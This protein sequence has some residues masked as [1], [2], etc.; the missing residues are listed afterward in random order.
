[1]AHFDYAGVVS[2]MSALIID[3]GLLTVAILAVRL[4]PEALWTELIARPVPGWLTASAT[5]AATLLPWAYFTVSWWLTG[6]TIG[7]ILIGVAV[8][9]TDG[10]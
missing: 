2:R 6:Q 3:L 5:I 9:R 1:V 10:W 4:L 8:L 7:N